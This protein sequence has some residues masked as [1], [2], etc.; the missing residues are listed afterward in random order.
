MK[1]RDTDA[2]RRMMDRMRSGGAGQGA[3]A[4]I[5]ETLGRH[6]LSPDGLV[7]S[8]PRAARAGRSAGR[9]TYTCE[10]GS[11]DYLLHLPKGAE[12]APKGLIL[13]LHGC[14]Q[15]PEDFATGTG[16]DAVADAHG[17]VVVYP[18]QSR[19]DNAQ[20]CWNW[21]SGADQHGGRGEPAILT[22]LAREVASRHGVPAHSIF[23][24]GLS[25]GAAMAVILGRTAPEV[26]AGIA[27]HSGLP[28]GSA[29][30]VAEAF[31]A[32]AAQSGGDRRRPPAGAGSVPTLVIH[33]TSDATV[34]PT[35]GQWIVDDALAAT[36]GAQTQ[37]VTQ[38][39]AGGRRYR[40][41]TS[42]GP[43]GRLLAEHWA[44]E[45]L[46][47]AWSGGNPAGSYADSRGPDASAEMV[48]FFLALDE[49]ANVAP[50]RAA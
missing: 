29:R 13:M 21:F 30:G 32:M 39:T 5:R 4:L 31:A 37:T 14:T 19:G 35:N 23:A 47:H 44:V 22:G 16:M 33:G 41:V 11:R 27:A 43:D 48:R 36:Q 3:D 45:G 18:A 2:M 8:V 20:S 10:A 15:T 25:A 50:I 38:G 7:A 42:L 40:Q 49:P 6:G 9:A 1:L 26:F 46:G 34:S 28:Y 24:A 17:L 12:T